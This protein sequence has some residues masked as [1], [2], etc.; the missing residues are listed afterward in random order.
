M[1]R[2]SEVADTAMRLVERVGSA[3]HVHHL[4]EHLS[5]LDE[6]ANS[7]LFTLRN[8]G[9]QGKRLRGVGLRSLALALALAGCRRGVV[10][11]QIGLKR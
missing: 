2:K 8:H 3:Q 11:N 9:A 7:R 5:G 6:Q 1:T 4:R 10:A